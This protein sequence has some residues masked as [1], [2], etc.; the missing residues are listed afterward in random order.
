VSIQIYEGERA[1]T[2]DNHLLGN[3][4]L[5]GIP[6]APRGVPQI[7]VTF[8]ID[9][10]GILNVTAKD[11]STGKTNQIVIKND[12][13]RLS[14]EEI[15][16]MIN[17]ADRFRADDQKQRDRVAAKNKLE[18]YVYSVKQAINEAQ[19]NNISSSDKKT[20]LDACDKEIKWIDSNQTA[21]KD[22]FEYHYNE[23]SRKCS[24]IM[25]NLHGANRDSGNYTGPKVEE[26][27]Y[28]V[29]LTFCVWT[30]LSILIVFLL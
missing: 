10:N 18:T 23:I 25:S 16:R 1:M 17:D 2:R 20:V 27:D 24:P 5:T 28:F 13:G 3:F 15:Q 9:A 19:G 7:E 26:V 8:D 12:K 11:V 29:K 30:F 22:E 14:K 21:E 4:D 6:P